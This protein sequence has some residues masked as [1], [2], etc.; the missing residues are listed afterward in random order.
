MCEPRSSGLAEA[1]LP[2]RVPTIFP[3]ASI[4]TCRPASRIRVHDVLPPLL[5]GV[6]VRHAA[7]ATLG[8]LAVLR[9]GF[10]VLLD[11]SAVHTQGSGLVLLRKNGGGEKEK[12]ANYVLHKGAKYKAA[13]YKA[14]G[15]LQ[16]AH[17]GCGVVGV[18][19]LLVTPTLANPARVGHPR[20]LATPP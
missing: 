3:A 10:E 1:S 14:E 9:Q 17:R 16:D 13:K 11:T 5:V 2:A 4:V 8:I 20:L 7:D 18:A 12:Q 15:E 6:G 19:Q